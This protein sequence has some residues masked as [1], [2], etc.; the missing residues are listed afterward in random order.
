MVRI[1]DAGT[2]LDEQGQAGLWIY[3]AIFAVTSG[4]AL[5]PTYAQAV[6]GGWVFGIAFGFPAAL[7]GFVSGSLIGY[8]VGRLASGD[9]AMGI[10]NE[11]PKWKAVCD[12]L[13]HSGFWK[14]LLIVALLRAPPNS[15]F[16]LTNLILS[17]TRTPRL[18]FVLATAL[19][20]A[21]RTLAYVVIGSMAHEMAQELTKESISKPWWMF[22]AMIVGTIIV[23][24]VVSHIARK[25]VAK[26]VN[27]THA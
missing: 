9:R 8:Q 15:P 10:I 19:G 4:L 2:W 22:V 6:L 12:A 21:P 5:M 16:A 17:A 24:A 1:G 3:V 27:S 7:L 20:M 14:T 13:V 11:N 26:V 23:I 25:A 18:V